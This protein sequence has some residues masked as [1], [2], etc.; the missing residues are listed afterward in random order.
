M[1]D[2]LT[3]NEFDLFMPHL[4]FIF[5]INNQNTGYDNLRKIIYDRLLVTTDTFLSLAAFG[6]KLDYLEKV[7]L[8]DLVTTNQGSNTD[9]LVRAQWVNLRVTS[10]PMSHFKSSAQN[11]ALLV[12]LSLRR[13][14]F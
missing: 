1:T 11:W 6:R 5:F 3:G 8:S 4:N 2:F 14:I 7:Y 10:A 9:T 13:N 12:A